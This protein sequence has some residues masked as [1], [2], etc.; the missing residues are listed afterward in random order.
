[1]GL[2]Q[3]FIN[4]QLGSTCER[5]TARELKGYIVERAFPVSY[6]VVI[7]RTYVGYTGALTLLEKIFTT[8]ISKSA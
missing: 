4:N 2:G 8:S 1:M 6:E 3:S 7:N 5:D